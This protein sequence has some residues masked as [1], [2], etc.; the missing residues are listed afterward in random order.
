[1][2][3]IRM[4][5]AVTACVVTA[6]QNRPFLCVLHKLIHTLQL[7]HTAHSTEVF[8]RR[9]LVIQPTKKI[10]KYLSRN[11]HRHHNLFLHMSTQD[12]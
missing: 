10:E 5:Y 8:C 11:Y 3:L 12:H 4:Q 1:M 6:L 2:S 9:W 7:A